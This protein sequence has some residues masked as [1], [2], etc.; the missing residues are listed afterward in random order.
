MVSTIDTIRLNQTLSS[1]DEVKGKFAQYSWLLPMGS[2]EGLDVSGR[3]GYTS[4]TFGA[5][6]SW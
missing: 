4:E 1:N 3:E 6:R 2:F 5:W